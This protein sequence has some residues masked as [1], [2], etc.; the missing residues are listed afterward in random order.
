MGGSHQNPGE[1]GLSTGREQSSNHDFFRDGGHGNYGER[2]NRQP[3]R[4]SNRPGPCSIGRGDRGHDK[5]YAHYLRLMES[6]H[7][8]GPLALQAVLAGNTNTPELTAQLRHDLDQF[9]HLGWIDPGALHTCKGEVPEGAIA[10]GLNNRSTTPLGTMPPD[11]SRPSQ[12]HNR[13]ED[14]GNDHA[15]F[16]ALNERNF[17]QSI[18][19]QR[20]HSRPGSD[21]Y[22]HSDSD[23]LYE[24]YPYYEESE[25]EVAYGRTTTF[26]PT[27]MEV[28]VTAASKCR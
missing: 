8:S 2:W 12:R 11:D 10:G 26:T 7:I 27:G 22:D 17:N 6:H 9:I 14:E 19:R 3:G 23:D 4:C 15:D 28:E 5:T 1:Y 25:S 21:Q 24:D 16:N 20:G 13:F 18:D